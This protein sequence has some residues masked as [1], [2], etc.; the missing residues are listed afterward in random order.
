MK[1]GDS[2][3]IIVNDNNKSCFNCY[4]REGRYCYGQDIELTLA[5]VKDNILRFEIDYCDMH[6]GWESA[7]D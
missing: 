2:L 5:D 3:D 7:N 4:L 6:R 1:E